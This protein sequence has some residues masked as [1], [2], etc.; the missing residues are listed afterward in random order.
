MLK[1]G[2]AAAG[3]ALRRDALSGAGARLQGTP[4]LD[5]AD[6]RRGGR[7]PRPDRRPTGRCAGGLRCAPTAN[8]VMTARAA[9][10]R[11]AA[12][13][14]IRVYQIALSP[15]IGRQCRY[16]PTCSSY[17]DEAI[18]RFGV[19]AG[20][21]MGL[22][23]ILRCQP[24][25]SAG[26]DPVPEALDPGLSLVSALAGWPLD[27]APHRSGDPARPSEADLRHARATVRER[28]GR[29]RTR[30]LRPGGGGTSPPTGHQ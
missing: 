20:G 12:H 18:G 21:W 30:P 24:F 29:R 1:E 15:L 22:A 5:A 26:F 17:T 13:G 19:W 3:R 8:P 4:R 10:G 16:L 9:P 25:G 28:R 14:L 2:G 11:A 7:L 23:R 27:G 6:L